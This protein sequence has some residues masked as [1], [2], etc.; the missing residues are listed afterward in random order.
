[1][2]SGIYSLL[3]WEV[4][5]FRMMYLGGNSIFSYLM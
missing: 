2:P 5:E 1:M 4:A 3:K